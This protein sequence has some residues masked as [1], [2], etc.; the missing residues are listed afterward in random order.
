MSRNGRLAGWVQAASP[1]LPRTSPSCYTERLQ[2]PQR[3]SFCYLL[4]S[5]HD[6][7]PR[8]DFVQLYEVFNTDT[9]RPAGACRHRLDVDQLF[10]VFGMVGGCSRTPPRTEPKKSERRPEKVIS[11][12]YEE[13]LDDWTENVMDFLWCLFMAVDWEADMV[14]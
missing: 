6:A 14:I 13:I 5:G 11:L 1:L 8:P 3:A 12:R 9:V 10:E 7:A 2:S 4:A